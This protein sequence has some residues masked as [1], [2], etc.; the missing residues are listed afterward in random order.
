MDPV[1][2]ARTHYVK[3]MKEITTTATAQLNHE[4]D[5][6]KYTNSRHTKHTT[7]K[8][9]SHMTLCVPFLTHFIHT[10]FLF[11][12]FGRCRRAFYHQ[13]CC[14]LLLEQFCFPPCYC[15]C[16]HIF[17]I[18]PT[19]FFLRS[20]LSLSFSAILCAF[21]VPNF[22]NTHYIWNGIIRFLLFYFV[23]RFKAISRTVNSFYFSICVCVCVCILCV[24]S[25]IKNRS[26]E[27]CSP[28]GRWL[29]FFSLS[30]FSQY[31]FSSYC[32]YSVVLLLYSLFLLR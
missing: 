18:F 27:Y 30:R 3:T 24:H 17:W 22:L 19:V 7:K 5:R 9:C 6:H 28:F 21:F 31:N 10:N 16:W 11:V 20:S 13:E 29:F 26:I 25:T 32:Y 4:T 14:E 8:K 12:K 15:C 23:V 1:R 2:R